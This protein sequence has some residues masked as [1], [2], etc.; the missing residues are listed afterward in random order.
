MFFLLLHAI[1]RF[2]PT[3]VTNEIE[4]EHLQPRREMHFFPR[5]A[6]FNN[7]LDEKIDGFI[8]KGL[9]FLQYLGLG[10]LASEW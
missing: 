7:L 3:K 10:N 4:A 5:L 8:N 9:L 6:D 1:E 2:V